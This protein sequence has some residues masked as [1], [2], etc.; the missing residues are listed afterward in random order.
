MGVSLLAASSTSFV[1]FISS[2]CSAPFST[3]HSYLGRDSTPSTASPPQL[4]WGKVLQRGRE[5]W[6]ISSPFV[7]VLNQ[8]RGTAG[9]R[10]S[11]AQA[12]SLL[13]LF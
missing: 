4:P 13:W 12:E 10:H 3:P 7:G 11:D 1:K 5:G 2:L 8:G 9:S 6:C